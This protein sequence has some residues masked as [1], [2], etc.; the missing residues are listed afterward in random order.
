MNRK[1]TVPSRHGPRAFLHIP[2]NVQLETGGLIPALLEDLS[3]S[4]ARLRIILTAAQR[5][6]AQAGVKFFLAMVPGLKPL[7]L[8]TWLVRSTPDSIALALSSGA[9]ERRLLRRLVSFHRL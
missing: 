3:E 8:E 2:V 7:V 9:R 6:E 4:G 5:T 1:P